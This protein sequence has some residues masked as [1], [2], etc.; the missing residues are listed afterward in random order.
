VNEHRL[1]TKRRARYY[2]IGGGGQRLDEA[3]IVLHGLGQLASV[4]LTYF[5]SIA[6]PER[7]IVAPEALNRYYI[8]PSPSGRTADAK[9]GTTWMTRMD[10]ENEIADYVDFLDAVYMETAVKA[11]RVTALGF[12]QGVAT[13]TRWVTMGT[14]RVD[15]L[16]AW[17]G[18]LPPEVEAT[19]LTRLSGG[20]TLVAGTED[21]YATWIAEGDHAGRL[22]AAGIKPEIVTFDGGH[23]MDRQAL[24]NLVQSKSQPS[25]R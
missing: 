23:R 24:E 7:L 18:Q 10:R 19:L 17:A 11:A 22:E 2:T 4:F 9:V 16:I 6:T 5:E 8:M 21:E 15:R 1:F 3:W 25:D 12:S 13:A 14:S 20:V